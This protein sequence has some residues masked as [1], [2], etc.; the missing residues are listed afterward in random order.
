[1]KSITQELVQYLFDYKDG[2]LIW[3]NHRWSRKNGS[4]AGVISR[5]GYLMVAIN[6]KRY[7]VH[8]IVWIWHKGELP[9]VLDHI[10]GDKTDNRIDN[11]RPTTMSENAWNRTS[12]GRNTS[13]HKGVTKHKASGKWQVF[14]TENGNYRYFGLYKNKD[15]AATIANLARFKYHGNFAHYGVTR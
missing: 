13:G 6:R 4:V 7:L 8:R 12:K 3:K 5:C 10:N 14:I 9:D 1:M 2:K 15:I 11:L